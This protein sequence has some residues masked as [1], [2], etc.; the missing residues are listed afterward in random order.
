MVKQK[1]LFD[2]NKDRR[3]NDFDV[4]V[5]DYEEAVRRKNERKV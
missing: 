3:R 2:E 5:V 4:I 1:K